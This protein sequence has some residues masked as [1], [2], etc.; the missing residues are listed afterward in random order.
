MR[1]TGARPNWT[2]SVT[3]ADA[4]AAAARTKEL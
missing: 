1:A 2:N 4:D 3:V